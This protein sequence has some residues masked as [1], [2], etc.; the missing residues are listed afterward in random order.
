MND[1]RFLNFSYGNYPSFKSR[2]ETKNGLDICERALDMEFEQDWSIDLGTTLGDGKKLKNI[3]LVLGI[4]F[5]EKLILCY[6]GASN[7]L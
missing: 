4:F 6:C 7:V 2:S 3:F 5:R 1:N